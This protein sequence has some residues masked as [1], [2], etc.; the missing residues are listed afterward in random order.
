MSGFQNG[1]KNRADASVS[2]LRPKLP[3]KDLLHQGP[4][5]THEQRHYII[6]T[7]IMAT[8]PISQ[9]CFCLFP[10]KQWKIE[11]WALIGKMFECPAWSIHLR[12][13]QVS[14]CENNL[15]PER[16]SWD[17]IETIIQHRSLQVIP[18]TL[19]DVNRFIWKQMIPV[20]VIKTVRS[21]YCHK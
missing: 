2:K 5:K 21:W 11:T 10:Q 4:S 15:W 13:N 6:C 19:P 18:L 16:N 20:W 1:D 3:Q 8:R 12:E 17:I 7:A 14:S 9:R